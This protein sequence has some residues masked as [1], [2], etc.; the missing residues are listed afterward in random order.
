MF[1]GIVMVATTVDGAKQ[2]QVEICPD[3]DEEMHRS[4]VAF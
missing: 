2:S 1:V 3:A 4:V